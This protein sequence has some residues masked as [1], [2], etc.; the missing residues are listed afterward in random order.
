ME[1]W[2]WERE[3]LDRFARHYETDEPIPEA[4]F[5]K[6]S[7][8]E[9]AFKAMGTMR[10]L[11]LAKLDLD[12]HRDWVL[13]PEQPIDGYLEDRLSN[14]QLKLKTRPRPLTCNF[15][16]LFSSPTGYAGYYSYKW[17]EVLVP[18]TF[19]AFKEKAFSIQRPVVPS[20]SVS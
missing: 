4:L 7:L 11:C 17:A 12:L 6:C 16:H 3:S 9:I 8:V 2:C 1:N 18:I 5:Q 15:G 10:Q 14:Y 19:T 13:D 20:E